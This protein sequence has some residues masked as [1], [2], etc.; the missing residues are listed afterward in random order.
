MHNITLD[1][2]CPVARRIR[3]CFVGVVAGWQTWDHVE[4]FNKSGIPLDAAIEQGVNTRRVC[5]LAILRN[6][7]CEASCLDDVNNA[8][9]LRSHVP[10]HLLTSSGS[11][12]CMRACTNSAAQHGSEGGC[13]KSSGEGGGGHG[14]MVRLLNCLVS[15]FPES[16]SI[17]C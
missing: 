14:A 8:I 2:T 5:S 10:S 7:S 9:G 17:I 11:T 6:C 12:V 4:S 13:L 3:C 1:R 16:L 15:K